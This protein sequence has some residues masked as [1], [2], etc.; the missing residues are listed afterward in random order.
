MGA[1][2]TSGESAPRVATK[3]PRDSE[4]LWH[5]IA[6]G[7]PSGPVV[8][9]VIAMIPLL[10]LF[11]SPSITEDKSIDADALAAVSPFLISGQQQDEAGASHLVARVADTWGY[12]GTPERRKVALQIGADLA[13]RGIEQITLF[14][15]NGLMVLRLSG[16]EIV[17][18][19]PHPDDASDHGR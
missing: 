17:M 5:R 16:G 15:S 14:D 2:T 6:R 19:V 13:E 8:I 18:L 7:L 11:M 9:G 10:Y 1:G 3:T 4:S 12:L